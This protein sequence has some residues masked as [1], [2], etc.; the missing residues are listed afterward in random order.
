VGVWLSAFPDS[1]HSRMAEFIR[2]NG[3]PPKA[4]T[5]GPPGT[6]WGG[7]GGMGDKGGRGGKGGK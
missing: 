2:I 6:P 7:R 1:T 5:G 3:E 4:G